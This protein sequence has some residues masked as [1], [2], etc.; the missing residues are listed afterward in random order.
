MLKE[1]KFQNEEAKFS[2]IKLCC[3]LIHLSEELVQD[4]HIQYVAFVHS[5]DEGGNVGS[6]F[7]HNFYKI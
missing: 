2:S 1:S 7:V 4:D 6:A 5:L 3:F